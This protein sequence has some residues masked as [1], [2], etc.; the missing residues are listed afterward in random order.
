MKQGP[1]LP[2][3]ALLGLQRTRPGTRR[4]ISGL[5]P[6]AQLIRD[7]VIGDSPIRQKLSLESPK[8]S[9]QLGWTREVCDSCHQL[10]IAGASRPAPHLWVITSSE[11]LVGTPG[12]G[13]TQNLGRIGDNQPTTSFYTW[14]N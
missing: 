1:L 12:L 8:A 11:C 2:S 3:L 4:G 10:S 7:P 5:G 9:G 13:K 6:M 14:R